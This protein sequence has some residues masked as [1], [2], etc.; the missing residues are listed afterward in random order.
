MSSIM[1]TAMLSAAILM[2]PLAA[3]AQTDN[4][5]AHA[6]SNS[7]VTATSTT[8][9]PHAAATKVKSPM[10]M[11]KNPTVPGATGRTVVPGSNSTVAG[12]RAGT[13][14]TKTGQTGMGGG[15]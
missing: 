3:F 13:I 10:A 1:R 9:N 14:E 4:P 11:A 5:M 8:A 15:K 7:S 2:T 12:D 6:G